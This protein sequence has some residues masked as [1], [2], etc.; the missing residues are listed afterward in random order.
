MFDIV[1]ISYNEPNAEEN[2][3]ELVDRF[4]W[5]KR[6][7]GVKGIREAHIRAAI[8]SY[9]EYVFIVDGD[10]KI[11][12]EFAFEAP[13]ERRPDTLVVWRAIN[14]VNDLQ[15]GYGGIKLFNRVRLLC[16][17]KSGKADFSMNVVDCVVPKEETACITAFNT[18]PFSAWR[19]GFRE[20]AKLAAI[21]DNVPY[22]DQVKGWLNAWCSVGADRLN[23]EHTI[24][25]AKLGVMFGERYKK[26]DAVMCMINDYD[27]LQRVFRG[28]IE[29]DS[30]LPTTT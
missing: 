17:E 13:S 14:A 28:E 10:A 30:P 3:D 19:A 18:D 26:H 27:W 22:A 9:T 21:P 12:P 5:A 7:H 15:Y 25:G 4:P 6:V 8:I 23:G 16:A 1:F 29:W 2:W 11:L 24:R 20:A